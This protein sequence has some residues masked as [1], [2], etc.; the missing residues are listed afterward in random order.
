MI[1]NP[2]SEAKSIVFTAEGL[3][4]SKALFAAMFTRKS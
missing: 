2:R 1:D 4:R 3:D